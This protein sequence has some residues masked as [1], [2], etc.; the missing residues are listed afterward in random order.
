MERDILMEI[1][2]LLAN[3]TNMQF[4]E[5]VITCFYNVEEAYSILMGVLDTY[6]GPLCGD[7]L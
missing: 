1:M 7:N 2:L 4:D 5:F 6:F 3:M